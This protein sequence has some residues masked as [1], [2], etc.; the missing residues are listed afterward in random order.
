MLLIEGEG[1][2]VDVRASGGPWRVERAEPV[3]GGRATFVEVLIPGG[4]TPGPCE[5]TIGKVRAGWELVA[6]PATP[7]RPFGP[8]DVIYQIMPDRFADGDPTNNQPAT[9]DRV[10]DRG[11]SHAY[12][13]GDLAGVRKRLPALADLGVTAV[14]LTPLYR[15]ADSLS[16]SRIGDRRRKVADFHGYAPVDFYAI[17]SRFGTFAEYRSLVDEAH[18]LGLKVIQDQIV[19]FTGPKHPWRERPPTD[20]WF[21]GPLDRPPSCTFRYEALVDPHAPDSERRGVTD[22]WFLGLLPDLN[23]RDERVVRYAIQQSAWWATLY[24]ADGVRLDT[25]PMVDRTFWRDWSARMQAERT[26]LRAVGEAMIWDAPTLSFFQGGRQGWDGV[27][28]GVASVFDFPMFGATTGV[29]K[30]KDPVSFLAEGLGRD[31]LYPRPDLLTTFLDNHDVD[32]LAGVPGV[33]PAR[34]RLAATFLLTSRGI[35]Q[36]AWGDEIGLGGGADDRRDYPGGF[37]GDPRDAFTPEGRTPDQ[38]R[39]FRTYRDLLHLRKAEPALRR[40]SLTSLVATDDCYIYLRKCEGSQV[41]VALNRGEKSRRLNLPGLAVGPA[42]LLFGDGSW[43]SD[44]DGPIIE[45]P[46]ESAAVLGLGR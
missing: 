43:T 39:L 5:L 27:D 34:L 18:A 9:G 20:S 15:V 1:L 13:G 35:P 30:G 37:P 23:M 8:D 14:W 41:L 2:D 19:G 32:R 22:G 25:Y 42:K 45:L 12:H 40:G 10:Y 7:P 11:D 33:T 21:H 6:T 24:E 4:S 3:P 44:G 29:F 17:N 46:A 16:D 31:H 26:G 36:I 28:P 38:D